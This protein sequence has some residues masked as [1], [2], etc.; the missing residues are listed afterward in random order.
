MQFS[1][2]TLLILFPLMYV[3]FQI[4]DEAPKKGGTLGLSIKGG[5]VTVAGSNSP[6]GPTDNV[7]AAA[8]VPESQAP[9]ADQSASAPS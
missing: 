8:S 1:K 3:G 5:I 6:L 2:H 9:P 4:A 7:Q